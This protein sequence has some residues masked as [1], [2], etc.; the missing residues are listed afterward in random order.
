MCGGRDAARPMA[1]K[2]LL[3]YGE[4]IALLLDSDTTDVE[5][6]QQQQRDLEDYL[7]YGDAAGW[8]TSP[9]FGLKQARSPEAEDGR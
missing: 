1:R 6:A 2:F 5:R 4:P 8:L 7:R 9:I 3:Q